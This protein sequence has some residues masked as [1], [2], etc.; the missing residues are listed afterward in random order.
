VI[1][2]G[3]GGVGRDNGLQ[4]RIPCTVELRQ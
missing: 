2:A 1:G 3:R 4:G